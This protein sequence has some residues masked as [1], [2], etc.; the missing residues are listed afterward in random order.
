MA[1]LL[2][3]WLNKSTSSLRSDSFACRGFAGTGFV[4]TRFLSFQSFLAASRPPASQR[5]SQP[6]FCRHSLNQLF[7]RSIRSYPPP[8]PPKRSPWE[9]FKRSVDEIEP[10]NFV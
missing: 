9:Q 10:T 3:L 8:A 2:Q 5:T 4:G 1:R 7:S 6:L